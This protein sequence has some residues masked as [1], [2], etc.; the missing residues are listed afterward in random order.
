MAAPAQGARLGALTCRYN[1]SANAHGRTRLRNQI[2]RRDTLSF[3]SC[4]ILA[5]FLVA[6]P[7][8]ARTSRLENKKKAMEKLEKLREKALGPKEKNGSTGKE[9]PPPANLL[10]PPAVVEASI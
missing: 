8:E 6:S 4:A 2:T 5:A 7:A 3:M 9:M 1:Q 10:I